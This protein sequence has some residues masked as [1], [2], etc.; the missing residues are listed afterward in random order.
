MF[1]PKTMSQNLC[2]I[3]ISCT[4]QRKFGEKFLGE[5]DMLMSSAS[6]PMKIIGVKYSTEVSSKLIN[7]TAEHVRFSQL[8]I[9]RQKGAISLL[10]KTSYSV[11]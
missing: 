6:Q 2:V 8:M 5:I 11:Y 1:L 7:S 4:N 10:K 9:S 3:V